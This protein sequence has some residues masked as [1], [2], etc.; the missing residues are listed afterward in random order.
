MSEGG[1]PIR[2]R[3]AV[4]SDRFGQSGHIFIQKERECSIES[5]EPVA[6]G[7]RLILS[8]I[9]MHHF[10]GYIAGYP[11]DNALNIYLFRFRGRLLEE[12]IQFKQTHKIKL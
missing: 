6:K 12:S 9:K 10:T 7:L 5:C 11:N 3:L 1:L 4:G 8:S 2:S